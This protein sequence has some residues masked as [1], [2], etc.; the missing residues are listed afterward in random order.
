[1]RELDLKRLNLEKRRT[2]KKALKIVLKMQKEIEF[3]DYDFSKIGIG[4]ISKLINFPRANLKY[5]K[6][7]AKKPYFGAESSDDTSMAINYLE[8]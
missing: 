5:L 8:Q 3:W 6:K 1:M 7:E 4:H 2:Q